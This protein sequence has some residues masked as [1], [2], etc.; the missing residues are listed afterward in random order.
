VKQ[1]PPSK[2]FQDVKVIEKNLTVELS[3]VF[4]YA[5]DYCFVGILERCSMFVAGGHNF[6]K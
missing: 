5:F 3:A 6:K 1:N 2:L 4:L